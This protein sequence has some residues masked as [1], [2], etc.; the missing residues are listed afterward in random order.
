M[1]KITVSQKVTFVCVATLIVGF[2]GFFTTDVFPAS[3]DAGVHLRCARDFFFAIA[4]QFSYPDWDPYPAGGRGALS[5]R[6]TGPLP[7]ALAAFFQLLGFSVP[8]AVKLVVLTFALAALWGIHRWVSVLHLPSSSFLWASVFFLSG[9]ILTFSIWYVFLFQNVCA[10]LL[11]PICL[12]GLSEAS[13]GNRRGILIAAIAYGMICWTHPQSAMM[14]GYA[15]VAWAFCEWATERTWKSF[16]TPIRNIVLM[17][18]FGILS[19]SPYLLPA[20]TST[21]DA[22][23]ELENDFLPGVTTKFLDDPFLDA[24]GKP[25][26]AGNA[27]QELVALLRNRVIETIPTLGWTPDATHPLPRPGSLYPFETIR[28][29]LALSAISLL[30]PALVGFFLFP[31]GKA[32][33]Y[34]I[35]G[36]IAIFLTTRWSEV[37][38]THFPGSWSFQ[39]VWRWLLPA[40]VLLIPLIF[41]IGS[42]E[43]ARWKR[44]IAFCSFVPLLLCTLSLQ[45]LGGTFSAE[46]MENVIRIASSS[47]MFLPAGC[48]VSQIS[49]HSSGEFHSLSIQGEKNS[50]EL[51][52]KGFAWVRFRASVATATANLFINTHFDRLWRLTR[53]DHAVLPHPSIPIQRV[54]S[55]GTMEIS[56]PAG[57]AEYLLDRESPPLRFLGWFLMAG[58]LALGC[59]LCRRRLS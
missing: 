1:K 35:P 55:D 14:V 43:T 48:P 51:L 6:F 12:A 10:L 27:L 40:Q 21:H 22:H 5:F 53:Q 2:A 41:Q 28:P 59:W 39:F 45:F 3:C 23:F 25:R 19:A 31:K 15:S 24:S 47:T 34:G 9:P 16:S 33:S 17:G 57:T 4:D 20:L 49:P 50:V 30:L 52:G 56:L 42:P 29:W 37:I 26:T 7:Y 38:W 46:R 18:T 58:C 11:F 44:G 36:L 13:I 8:M 32:L 54:A